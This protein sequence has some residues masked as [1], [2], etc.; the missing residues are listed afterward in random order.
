MNR[1]KLERRYGK[2]MVEEIVGTQR[3]P[4]ATEMEAS[5]RAEVERIKK[6]FYEKSNALEAEKT[7]KFNDFR[8]A[9]DVEYAKK[10]QAIADARDKALRELEEM[11]KSIA[12]M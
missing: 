10:R 8:K 2:K 11:A 7:S 12:T 3:D 9:L 4:I 6:E 1:K 5:R